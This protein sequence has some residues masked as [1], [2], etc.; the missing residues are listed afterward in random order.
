MLDL[1]QSIPDNGIYDG[2]EKQNHL[3]IGIGYLPIPNVVIKAD[4][5]L[6]HTGPVNPRSHCESQSRRIALSSKQYIY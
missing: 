2:T 3:I 1:N 4:V 5:R 6:L